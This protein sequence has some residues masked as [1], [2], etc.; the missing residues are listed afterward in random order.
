MPPSSTSADRIGSSA[1]HD[2][3]LDGEAVGGDAVHQVADPLA[4]VIGERQPLQMRVEVAAQIVDHALADPDRRVVVPAGSARRRRNGRRRCRCRRTAAASASAGDSSSPSG[5]RLA[6]VLP[7]STLSM[8]ICSGHGFNSSKPAIRKTCASAQATASDAL[9]DRAGTLA[10]IAAFRSTRPG[11]RLAAHLRPCAAADR[12]RGPRDRLDRHQPGLPR[13]RLDDAVHQPAEADELPADHAEIDQPDGDKRSPPPTARRGSGCRPPAR[14]SRAAARGRSCEIRIAQRTR[15][16][17]FAPP[18]FSAT[19][20]TSARLHRPRAILRSHLLQ[21]VSATTK[22]FCGS[23]K[24]ISPP[25]SASFSAP[26]SS[27]VAQHEGALAP[28]MR[29]RAARSSARPDMVLRL[30]RPA[31]AI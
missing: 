25:S 10:I 20:V 4:A 5:R 26:L 12:Q 14:R 31:G 27:P 7:P 13:D 17:R 11:W 15:S 24:S 19:T 22:Y 29:A 23:R 2:H 3:R 8:T 30:H 16:S 18:W 6:D 21:P 9:S 28:A 1:V